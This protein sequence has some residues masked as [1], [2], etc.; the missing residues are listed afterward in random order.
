MSLLKTFDN[1]MS[2]AA[3]AE[4]FLTNLGARHTGEIQ[5]VV[6]QHSHSLSCCT[7]ALKML[8]SLIIEPLG[9]VFE[10]GYAETIDA[11]QRRAQVVGDG[12]GECFQ[13]FI[14]GG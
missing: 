8:F 13:R 5:E 7:D 3:D 12:V 4:S 9:I 11:A 1:R 6:N 14:G 10:Q 2:E